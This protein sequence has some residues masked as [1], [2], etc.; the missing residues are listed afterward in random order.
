MAVLQ[1]EKRAIELIKSDPKSRRYL[2]RQS[3]I[4]HAIAYHPGFFRYPFA[5]YHYE[6]FA[7]FEDLCSGSLKEAAWIAFRES[8]KT[9]VAK[10]SLE[11]AIVHGHRRY[12]NWD[13]YDKENAE[14]ALFDVASWL[15]TNQRLISD[16]GQLY[17]PSGDDRSSKMKR[18]GAFITEPR[19]ELINGVKKEF[20][21][22][23]V[24]AF[25]TQ[26]STR[27]RVFG[28]DAIRPDLYII[29]DFET[30]KTKDSYAATRKVRAHIEEAQA[31]LGVDGAILYLGNYITEEGSVQHVMDTLT[32]RDNA[33]V[34]D[35]PVMDPISGELA[36][37]G[38]YVK[39]KQQ[40]AKV[41]AG[42]LDPLRRVVSIEQKREDLTERVFQPEMMNNPT[43]SGDLVFDRVRIE[44]L[45]RNAREPRKIDAG[46]YVFETYKPGHRYALGADTS[47]GNGNDSNTTAIIDFTRD[48][49]ILAAD[50]ASNEIDS[51]VLGDEIKREG[52]IYG[53]CYVAPEINNTGHATIARLREI[54]PLGMIHMREETD[55]VKKTKEKRLGWRTGNNK[56]E[57]ILQLKAAVEDGELVIP[58]IRVL[59]EMKFYK[60]RDLTAHKSEEGATRHFDLLMAVAIAWAMRPFAP[61]PT[62]LLKKQAYVQKPYEPLSPFEGGVGEQQKKTG[63]ILDNA[64]W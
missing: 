2:A 22:V 41:N 47:E 26:Q 23:K 57:I 50:F 6:L 27:G 39:T 59:E 5:P 18:V 37:P 33:M 21:P 4:Y 36:W 15:Q 13:A 8:A 56:S 3:A 64:H 35:I 53:T 30:S 62:D 11:W 9:S 10:V 17:F 24:E 54:Y 1:L 31:G 19:T 44:E 51:H 60:L 61:V 52:E 14:Q 25:S 16:Y 43:Q 32:P 20:P 38:K 48:K 28:D 45:M 7:D 58:D 34:R 55:A 40:A 29:D 12:V 46:M 49:P 63:D 42:I